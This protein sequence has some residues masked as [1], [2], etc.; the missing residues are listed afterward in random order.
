MLRTEFIKLA[1][2]NPLKNLINGNSDAP[3]LGGVLGSLGKFFGAST[4]SNGTIS[5]LTSGASLPGTA[6][7]IDLASSLPK[8]AAGT[9]HWS[10]GRALIGELGPEIAELPFGSRVV[11]AGETRRML[12]GNDNAPAA[13]FHFDLR[14]AVMT[15]D[16]LDQMNAIGAS[17]AVRG[18]AGG[19]AMAGRN[20]SRSA[21]RR[22]PGT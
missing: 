6:S 4:G 1:L 7:A 10:G 11:P 18:A 9:Q 8:L 2:L 22:L 12:A 14:G 5:L 20:A 21:R 19:A 15:Q 17:A 13:Q 3:T 16:L